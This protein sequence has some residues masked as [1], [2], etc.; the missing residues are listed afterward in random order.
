MGQ[1]GA[2]TGQPAGSY[3]DG[4][5]SMAEIILIP[6]RSADTVMKAVS[7]RIVE[8][9]DIERCRY[10]AG[11]VRDQRLAT[12]DHDGGVVRGTQRLD[13]DRRGL[14]TDEETALPVLR[15][16]QT[17]GYFV[18]TASSRIARPS[19]EQRRVAVLLADQVASVVG[20]APEARTS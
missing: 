18:L 1:A 10:V 7:A 14:P 19:L 9:L 6:H 8:V 13:V 2:G 12:M 4:L 20:H 15:D 17:L 5:L 3:L 16:G 11:P